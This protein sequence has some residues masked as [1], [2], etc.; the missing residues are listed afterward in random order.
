MSTPNNPLVIAQANP[1]HP[2]QHSAVH[3]HWFAATRKAATVLA[4]ALQQNPDQAQSLVADFCEAQTHAAMCFL[5]W[6]TTSWAEIKT[7][8]SMP[9]TGG[10]P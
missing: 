3:D 10:R 8:P 9:E 7:T 1:E 4:E 2:W 5:M 6:A